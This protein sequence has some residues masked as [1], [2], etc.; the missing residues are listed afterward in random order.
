[1]VKVEFGQNRFTQIT[2]VPEASGCI[3]T[4]VVLEV[5]V[6]SKLM[7]GNGVMYA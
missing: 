1:M 3:L 4:N 2:A 7:M 6:K 5:S